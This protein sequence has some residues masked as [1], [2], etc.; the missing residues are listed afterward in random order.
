MEEY[1]VGISKRRCGAEL[2]HTTQREI[3]PE[4]RWGGRVH[5]T[6]DDNGDTGVKAPRTI[7]RGGV[8]C[9]RIR[10]VL[11]EGRQT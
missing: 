7:G 6:Q 8:G 11:H 3:I 2:I 1:L 4:Y 9:Y 5:L 10:T